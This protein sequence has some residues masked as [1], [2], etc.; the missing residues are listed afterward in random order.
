MSLESLV[1]QQDR[2]LTFAPD[3]NF[4]KESVMGY[5]VVFNLSV[6]EL[7]RD[8]ITCEGESG[9][10]Y[11]G[12]RTRF[13]HGPSR[14]GL[15]N[16]MDFIETGLDTLG[17][18]TLRITPFSGYD[19]EYVSN[20]PSLPE[21]PDANKR[22]I[23]NRFGD[24]G[25]EDVRSQDVKGHYARLQVKISNGGFQEQVMVVN[26]QEGFFDLN[27]C[28]VSFIK[29][30]FGSSKPLVV[31]VDLVDVIDA[32]SP[33][34]PLYF[35]DEELRGY[36][37]PASQSHLFTD[38]VEKY[39]GYKPSLW[40]WDDII[41]NVDQRIRII[42]TACDSQAIKVPVLRWET[43]DS[44][45]RVQRYMQVIPEDLNVAREILN[46][47]L[48]EV[49]FEEGKWRDLFSRIVGRVNEFIPSMD[50]KTYSALDYFAHPIIF[51]EITEYFS[52]QDVDLLFGSGIGWWDEQFP[53]CISIDQPVFWLSHALLVD[54][55]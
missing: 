4:A 25:I 30:H 42:I 18:P 38:A 51:R 6:D 31:L 17:I 13:L 33:T 19:N 46:K 36:L 54:R 45:Q 55:K 28:Y 39:L 35:Q 8:L 14:S 24:S 34:H 37:F 2:G 10:K 16:I 53:G 47:F 44:T 32:T 22:S 23:L 9:G 29:P 1:P 41:F 27:K 26:G 40:E 50:S 12:N 43:D 3:R 52:K 15:V 48:A 21:I 11:G 49:R 20:K 7:L 5:P